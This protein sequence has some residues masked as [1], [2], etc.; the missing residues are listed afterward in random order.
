MNEIFEENKN[1]ILTFRD[2]TQRKKSTITVGCSRPNDCWQRAL[3]RQYSQV[4]LCFLAALSCVSNTDVTHI[5]RLHSFRSCGFILSWCAIQLS[6]GNSERIGSP[7]S[8]VI[9]FSPEVLLKVI[10]SGE[11]RYLEFRKKHETPGIV[12]RKNRLYLRSVS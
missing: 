8:A 12:W 9:A 6:R 3:D 5:V 11:F 7:V 10:Y 1:Y 4:M 2:R